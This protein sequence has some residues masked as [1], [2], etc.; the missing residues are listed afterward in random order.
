MLTASVAQTPYA[1][2]ISVSRVNT[3]KRNTFAV[4]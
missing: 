2:P 4:N 1:T 3:P